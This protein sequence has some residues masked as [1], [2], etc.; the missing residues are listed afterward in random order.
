MLRYGRAFEGR[1]LG[2]NIKGTFF[3]IRRFSAG[4]PALC[5]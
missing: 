2:Q 4:S 3:S 5:G 1:N